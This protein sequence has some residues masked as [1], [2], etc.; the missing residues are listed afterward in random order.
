[1]A[2]VIAG[3]G[4]DE[5]VELAK[6]VTAPILASIIERA[7]RAKELLRLTDYKGVDIVC[8]NISDPTLR[9]A[10]FAS[11]AMNGCLVTAGAHGGGTVS[12]DVRRLPCAACGSS[13]RPEQV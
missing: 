13:E 6:K 3:A 12:L 8:E 10:A 4:A 2:T 9:P 7:I 11:Q 5:R 1:L